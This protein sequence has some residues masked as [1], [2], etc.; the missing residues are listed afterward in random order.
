[1]SVDKII[2]FLNYYSMPAGYKFENK[3]VKLN[4]LFSNLFELT[5]KN[6]PNCSK[7]EDV[8]KKLGVELP[9]SFDIS[10]NT[11]ISAKCVEVLAKLGKK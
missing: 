1:M 10:Q 4:D 8:A 9:K 3:L 2:D 11:A 7:L 5:S 6:K